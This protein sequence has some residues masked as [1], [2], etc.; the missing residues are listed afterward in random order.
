MRQCIASR[1]ASPPP[2]AAAAAAGAAGPPIYVCGDSH[3][4]SPAWQPVLPAGGGGGD[5]GP[6]SGA[7]AAAVR[8]L[9]PKLVTG[10]KHWHLRP[11]GDFY[12]KAKAA[13]PGWPGGE[14]GAEGGGTKAFLFACLQVVCSAS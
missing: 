7:G 12:P 11:E 13:G 9:V 8:L 10:L 14:E 1:S 6:G 5:G 4:L 3:A 2:A